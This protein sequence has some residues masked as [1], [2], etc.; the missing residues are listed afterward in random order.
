MTH[1]PTWPLSYSTDDLVEASQKHVSF[2]RA[3]HRLGT[4]ISPVSSRSL[5]RYTQLWL[6]LV[7]AAYTQVKT[8]T[9]AA[10]ATEASQVTPNDGSL[11][12][13]VPPPDVAWL[14]HCHRLAPL[15]YKEYVTKTFHGRL[16]EADP[17]FAFQEETPEGED[18]NNNE[19]E[20]QRAWKKAYPKEPFFLPIAGMQ[21]TG[22]SA[23]MAGKSP[24]SYLVGSLDLVASAQNQR[25]FL[26]QVSGR[27]YQSK[28]F[29][30]EGVRRYVQFLNV[31]E[32]KLPLVPT[33][34]IDLMW[35]THML[36]S[37]GR[38]NEDCIRIRGET[39]HHDDSLND[40]TPGSDLDV[41]FRASM[42]LW[43]EKYQ[44]ELAVE[45][46]M[47]R[48]EPPA[49]Y[50]MSSWANEKP[51]RYDANAVELLGHAIQ[52]AMGATSSG[53]NSALVRQESSFIKQIKWTTNSKMN[54]NP[55]RDGYVFG[56]GKQGVGYY[57]LDPHSEFIDDACRIL[58]KRLNKRIQSRQS[59]MSSIVSCCRGQ[60]SPAENRRYD[61]I[62]SEIL[63]MRRMKLNL[64]YALSLRE[65]SPGETIAKSAIDNPV[66][67]SNYSAAA[68]CGGGVPA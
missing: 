46:G 62:A 54:P 65:A 57:S 25:T 51:D 28:D 2:L 38:Y 39:F 26:W 9:N 64:E 23:S 8:D 29:L 3:M 12:G 60:P 48:G 31:T 35:H 11:P 44:E 1:T 49:A 4:S 42:A 14:W 5:D 59:E 15:H 10:T 22:H 16:L 36:L 43:R 41:A 17:P 34:Q 53:K 55:Q 19:D 32:H 33:Y 47:H 50:F 30:Q 20:A 66:W 67:Y 56:R 37:V 27:S 24:K 61:Q 52:G 58:I 63:E 21:E 45:G 6:P 13:L 68:A 40:R 7:A 18:N